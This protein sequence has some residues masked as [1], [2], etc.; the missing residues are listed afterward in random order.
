LCAHNPSTY[1]F[2]QEDLEFE[3]SL[4]YIQQPCLERKTIR[5]RKVKH[6]EEEQIQVPV[7]LEKKY[8]YQTKQ[9]ATKLT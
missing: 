7:S 2:I 4:G 3:D 1:E 8:N 6:S 5:K 9:T